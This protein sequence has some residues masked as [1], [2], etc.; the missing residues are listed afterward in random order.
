MFGFLS[1]MFNNTY[2]TRKVTDSYEKDGV[3]V[4]T[5]LVNNSSQPYET[6]VSHPNYNDDKLIIVQ[7]YDTE[8]QA[9]KGH[10][11]WIKKMT[12][13]ELPKAIKDVSTSDVIDF[14]RVLGV[15]LNEIYRKTE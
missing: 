12:A 11:K 5:C 8:E 14:A 15:D 1:E 9:Q 10:K 7:M 6:A 3:F 4:D 13:K 2:E